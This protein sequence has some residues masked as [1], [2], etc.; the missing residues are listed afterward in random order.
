MRA[1]RLE[2]DTHRFIPKGNIKLSFST[3]VKDCEESD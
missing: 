1:C 3:I 2:V